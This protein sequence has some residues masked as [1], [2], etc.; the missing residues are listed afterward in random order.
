MTFVIKWNI[1]KLCLF[2]SKIQINNLNLK[3]SGVSL[4]NSFTQTQIQQL[5]A[6]MES[7]VDVVLKLEHER[8]LLIKENQQQ[9]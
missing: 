6:S 1:N 3:M 9:K 2:F 7:Q 5:Q 4:E 8:L